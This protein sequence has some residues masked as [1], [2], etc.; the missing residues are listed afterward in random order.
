[1]GPSKVTAIYCIWATKGGQRTGGCLLGGVLGA[2]R[3]HGEPQGASMSPNE[4]KM[5]AKR[6]RKRVQKLPFFRAGYEN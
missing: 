2:Q 3:R 5:E 4:T 1:L 6:L